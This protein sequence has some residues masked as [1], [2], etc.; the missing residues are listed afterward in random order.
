MKRNIVHAQATESVAEIVRLLV[1]LAE[2]LDELE[3]E[4]EYKRSAYKKSLD[5]RSS[6]H[7]AP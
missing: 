2:K 5:A 6:D 3:P 4:P 1:E 7:P